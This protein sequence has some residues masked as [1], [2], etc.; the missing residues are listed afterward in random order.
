[1]NGD[2]F[3]GHFVGNRRHGRGT[4]EYKNGRKFEGNYRFDLRWG[5]GL[6]HFPNGAKLKGEWVRG[7]LVIFLKNFLG[8]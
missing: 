1:M 3:E 5:E 6:I 8:W 7:F 2:K 4:F